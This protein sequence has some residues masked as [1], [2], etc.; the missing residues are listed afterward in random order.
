[1]V[2]DDLKYPLIH[3][4]GKQ[5]CGRAGDSCRHRNSDPVL[6]SNLFNGMVCFR[7]PG[8]Q[9]TF[10]DLSCRSNLSPSRIYN[11]GLHL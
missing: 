1:M 10:N 7:S 3:G 9:N 4:H 11:A 6:H 5:V 8:P 2:K